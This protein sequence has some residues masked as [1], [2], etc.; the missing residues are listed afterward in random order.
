MHELSIAEEIIRII[1]AEREK[2]GFQRVNSVSLRAG[3]LSCVEPQ[4]LQFAFEVLRE[5][6]CAAEGALDIQVTDLTLQCRDCSHS[7]S[8]EYG[9][10][11]CEKCGSLDLKLHGSTDF[12]ILSI[13]VD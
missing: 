5:G 7:M 6:T 8:A 11:C 12:Q 13:E 3:A 9:P 2:H 4:A 10:E 1:E